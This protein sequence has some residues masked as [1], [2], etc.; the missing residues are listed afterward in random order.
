MGQKARP[1]QREDKIV[2]RFV[3]PLLEAGR[4]LDAVER[5]VDLDRGD[6]PAGIME[7]IALARPFWLEAAAPWREHPAA[8]PDPHGAAVCHRRFGCRLRHPSRKGESKCQSKP[9]WFG[10]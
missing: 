5:A 7:F 4:G 2:R 3:M 8:D 1:L 10:S 9:A 6:M